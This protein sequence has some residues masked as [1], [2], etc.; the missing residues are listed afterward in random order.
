MP[1]LMTHDRILRIVFVSAAAFTLYSGCDRNKSKGSAGQSPNTVVA[2]LKDDKITLSD[3][4]EAAGAQ[5]YQ[6]RRQALDQLIM[7]RLIKNAASKKNQTEEQFLKAEID[8]KI[9]PPSDE[10]IKEMYDKSAAQLPPGAT[11]EEYKP[12]IADFLTRPQ[13]QEKARALFDQLKKEAEV[14]V[15][16]SEPRKQVEAKGPARGPDSAKITIVEFSDFECPFCSRANET[17]DKVMEAYAGKVRLVFRHY[18]LD[19]HKK[20]PKAAEAS[21]CANEQG[22]FWEYHNQ[23]FANQQKLDPP[24]LKE[25]ATSVGLDAAKFSECLDSGKMASVVQADMAAGKKAGV[26]GTPAFFINGVMLSGAQPLE[27]FKRVIDQELATN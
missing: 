25:H 4:D 6:V 11:F 1:P 27:E 3:L 13:K 21:L 5:L 12:R 17:V 8:D 10:Q 22:K 26:N 2:T 7:E 20:A 9:T 23:L 18:P 14:K 24:Q 16:L 15:T 19:F